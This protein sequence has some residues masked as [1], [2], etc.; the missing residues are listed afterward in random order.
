MNTYCYFVIHVQEYFVNNGCYVC[1][2]L[3][4]ILLNFLHYHRQ[5]KC[6]SM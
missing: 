3:V 6:M 5:I 2:N 1:M 4:K